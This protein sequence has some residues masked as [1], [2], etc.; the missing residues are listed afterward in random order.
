MCIAKSVYDDAYLHL[1]GSATEDRIVAYR[2]QRPV[3]Q[4]RAHGG[5]LQRR[6]FVLFGTNNFEYI[7]QSL[8]LL[9]REGRMID[10]QRV[11]HEQMLEAVF[12]LVGDGAAALIGG[13]GGVRRW[14]RS[15]C[16]TRHRRRRGRSGVSQRRRRRRRRRSAGLAL[17]EG[18]HLLAVAKDFEQ[19]IRARE[20]ARMQQRQIQNDFVADA[21]VSDAAQLREVRL[22]VAVRL[23]LG[24][25]QLV[26]VFAAELFQAGAQESKLERH[27]AML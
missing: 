16:A 14:R 24:L 22:G 10:G 19:R 20:V 5:T 27:A 7:L 3:H 15:C 2:S 17:E 12:L 18:V 1:D 4:I 23:V 9:A 21:R 8:L 6:P 26:V 25:A 13:G 11:D